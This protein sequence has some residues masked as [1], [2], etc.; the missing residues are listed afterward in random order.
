MLQPTQPLALSPKSGK[1]VSR[2]MQQVVYSQLDDEF[3]TKT[4]QVD[5]LFQLVLVCPLLGQLRYNLF[6]FVYT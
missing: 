1:F 6:S 2:F 4:W 3:W 5:Y